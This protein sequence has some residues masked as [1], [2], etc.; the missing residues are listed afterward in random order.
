MIAGRESPCPKCGAP[1]GEPCHSASNRG[2]PP[3]K[4]RLDLGGTP[5]RSKGKSACQKWLDDHAGYK[6]DGCLIWPFSG[7]R[8]YGHFK[9][10]GKR[11][12][13]HRYMCTLIH[14][15]PPSDK[16]QASHSCGRGHEGCV[17]PLHLSWK[18][19]SENQLDRRIHG[20]TKR[21]GNGWAGKVTIAQAEEIRRLAPKKT[22]DELAGIFGTSRGNIQ[23]ILNGQTK[24]RAVGLERQ[25]IITA[26][27]KAQ[28]PL[29][30]RDIKT[31]ARLAT[32]RAAYSML[33][34]MVNTGVIVRSGAG[35]YTLP[36][37]T[38]GK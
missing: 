23:F 22:Q 3:H 13:A 21:N 20:T 17:H 19:Q 5:H 18:T 12:Y 14:G 10:N 30:A 7:P 31:S 24:L 34:R 11:S 1:K 38:P 8:G 16:H 28:R 33:K 6:G 26:L 37:Q 9:C 25:R 27:T 2:V 36:S 15:D 35:E 4:E 29:S 32:D